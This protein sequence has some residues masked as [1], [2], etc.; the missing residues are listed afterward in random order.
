MTYDPS[1]HLQRAELLLQQNRAKDAEAELKQALAGEPDNGYILSALARCKFAQQQFKEGLTLVENAIAVQPDEDFLFYLKAFAG[2][3]LNKFDTAIADLQTAIEM[4]PYSAEY[5]AL[6]AHIYL[7][8]KDFNRALD[9]ANEGLRL[10]PEN[11]TALNARSI[12]LNKTK[13][14]DEAIETM[15]NALNQDPENYMTHTTAGWNLLEKGRN[16][17][18]LKHFREALRINPGMKAAQEG[19][20]E[21]LKSKIPPYRWFLQYSFW[22]QNKGAGMRW[23]IVIGLLAGVRLLSGTSRYFGN[24]NLSTI[25]LSIYLAFVLFT[26]AITPLANIFLLFH[27]DGKY[28]LNH[29]EKWGAR[30]LL[31]C[32]ALA[33]TMLGLHFSGMRHNYEPNAYLYIAAVLGVLGIPMGRASYP[34]GFRGVRLGQWIS[35]AMLAAAITALAAMPFD[36]ALMMLAIGA[37]GILFVIY[38]WLGGI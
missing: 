35:Y 24:E 29:N 34:L 21:A 19:L 6:L 20:K 11:L 4:N 22:L 28:A 15:N 18:A 17:D 10:D 27:P 25:I 38:S 9:Q 14:V 16:E 7:E 30:S 12:A 36:G 8:K 31:I 13:R 26:W 32:I 2:Y 23:V 37:Y 3:Q 5:F 1:I 33:L